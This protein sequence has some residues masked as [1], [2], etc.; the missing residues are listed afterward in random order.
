MS[1]NLDPNTNNNVTPNIQPNLSQPFMS[2][3]SYIENIIKTKIL[4]KISTGDDIIDGVL[5]LFLMYILTMI[6]EKI[7]NFLPTVPNLVMVYTKYFFLTMPAKVSKYVLY[8]ILKKEKREFIHKSI[9]ISYIT[10][11]KNI[12]ELYKAVHWYLSNAEEI[13]FVR[14]T[15]LKFT[16][17]KKIVPDMKV[18]YTSENINKFVTTNKKKK[19]QYKKHQI[20][21]TL[22]NNLITVYTDKDRKRENY[23]ITLSTKIDKKTNQDI[24]EDF[25]RYCLAEY[26]KNLSSS[27]WEQ[28]IFVNE[29]NNWTAKPSN[30]KRK[31]DT[32]ILQD[33]L[34]DQI[35]EDVEFFL[36]SEKWYED[37]DVPYT[38]GYLFYG[39]PGTGK[40]SM[41]KALS[42]HCKRH[43]HFLIL[44]NVESDAQLLDLLSKI[45]YKETVLVIEDIDC[46]D[47]IVKDR[48]LLKKE[49]EQEK[50]KKKSK[51]KSKKEKESI[52]SDEESEDEEENIPKLD[53]PYKMGEYGINNNTR[54]NTRSL[55]L[56]GLLNAIDGPFTTNGRIMIMTTNHPEVLDL[57]LIRGGR[58]DKRFLFD[59][60][61]RYQIKSL[62]EMYFEKPCTTEYLDNIPNR[63]Y[64]PAHITSVFLRKR[65]NPYEAFDHLDDEEDRPKIEPIVKA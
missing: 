41:I 11:N 13:D 1:F 39:H 10:D 21:Y 44:S 51:K 8:N 56:S 30:N 52:S 64:S 58:V 27:V 50:E 48:V 17:E 26:S 42:L 32:V 47:K 24:L 15:P 37:R 22:S 59:Y 55:T 2:P 43:I 33:G 65:D 53:K 19:L 63:K 46:A 7:K 23:T 6:L 25:S 61:N 34:K 29:G 40:T 28:K 16:Y 12:N 62:F 3:L 45:N 60:C 54:K 9:E 20:Y 14:E 36:K 18:D 31:I 38:R 57:A 4:Q 35:K 5:T 49:M